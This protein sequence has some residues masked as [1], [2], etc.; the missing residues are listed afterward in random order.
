MEGIVLP[1]V[2][3][4]VQWVH[5]TTVGEQQ[6]RHAIGINGNRIEVFSGLQFDVN[7]LRRVPL[8]GGDVVI[9]MGGSA[10]LDVPGSHVLRERV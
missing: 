8:G 1:H 3:A 4:H 6:I 10:R 5:R 9:S 7:R 2:V